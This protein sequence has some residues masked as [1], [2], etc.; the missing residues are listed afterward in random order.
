MVGHYWRNPNNEPSPRG[1]TAASWNAW[2]GPRG[3][4]FCLDYSVGRRYLERAQRK[5]G[6]SR[7]G[8]AAMRWPERELVFDDERGQHRTVGFHTR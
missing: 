1:W 2:A 4:V 3:N 6:S 7:Y 8:L 5:P